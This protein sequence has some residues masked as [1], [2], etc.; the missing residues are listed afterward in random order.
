[1]LRSCLIILFGSALRSCKYLCDRGRRIDAASIDV[2]PCGWKLQKRKQSATLRYV[3]HPALSPYGR[4]YVSNLQLIG[5]RFWDLAGARL[6]MK[7]HCQTQ[8]SWSCGCDYVRP[9]KYYDIT[10]L[11]KI[12]HGPNCSRNCVQVQRPGSTGRD[13]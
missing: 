13:R 2:I 1:M 7:L 4:Q 3:Q 6:I 5:R 10:P 11:V 9:H 8:F 12:E